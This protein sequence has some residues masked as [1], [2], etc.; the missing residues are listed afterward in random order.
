MGLFCVL[1]KIKLAIAV[2][3]TAALFVRD[4]FEII[5]VPPIIAVAVGIL[6]VWWIISVM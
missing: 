1:D 4:E 2:I 5:L 3:K 6:W